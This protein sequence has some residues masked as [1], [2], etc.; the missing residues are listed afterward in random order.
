MFNNILGKGQ[1]KKEADEEELKELRKQ[2]K[3]IADE[4]GL[5]KNQENDTPAAAKPDN[6]ESGN[7]QS[8]APATEQYVDPERLEENERITNLIMQQIKEL[9]E[10]DNNLNVKIKEIENKMK[11]NTSTTQY[12]KDVVDKFHQRLESIEKNMEKFMGLY[13]VVTSRFNPFVEEDQREMFENS[14][15]NQSKNKGI[16]IPDVNLGD[17]REGLGSLGESGSDVQNGSEEARGSIE[18]GENKSLE[19]EKDSEGGA[20]QDMGP[21]NNEEV[22]EEMGVGAEIIVEAGVKGKIDKDAEVYAAQKINGLM[23]LVS[24]DKETR[25]KVVDSVAKAINKLVVDAIKNHSKVTKEQIDS[26]LQTIAIEMGVGSQFGASSGE[27]SLNEHNLSYNDSGSLESLEVSGEPSND[28]KNETGNSTLNTASGKESLGSDTGSEDGSLGGKKEG[29]ANSELSGNNKDILG[30]EVKA[31]KS[32]D[33]TKGSSLDENDD[34]GAQEHLNNKG[35]VPP[36]FHFVLSDGI[37]V[38]SVRDLIEALK[39]I[40]EDTFSEHVN[41]DGNEFGQWLSLALSSPDLEDKFS[42]V[43]DRQQMISELEKLLA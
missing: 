5:Q 29:S 21:G 17:F 7:N 41:D 42:G 14:K 22:F 11:S 27:S 33:S 6:M 30:E 28:M 36:E 2:F 26:S 20:V 18:Q 38:K 35:P 10:I 32:E 37:E 13:E 12:V 40:D 8:N 34:K 16:D 25:A 19:F 4:K 31:L 43:K 39:K 23:T 3:E 1:G 24:E 15:A 9:I